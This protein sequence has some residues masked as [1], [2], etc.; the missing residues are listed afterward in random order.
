[1]GNESVWDP[2]GSRYKI[3]P[4]RAVVSVGSMMGG[5]LPDAEERVMLPRE[6]GRRSMA[7]LGDKWVSNGILTDFNH[8]QPEWSIALLKSRSKS[9]RDSR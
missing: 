2:Q 6:V 1:M 4:A 9:A 5:S 3:S 7:E 8:E